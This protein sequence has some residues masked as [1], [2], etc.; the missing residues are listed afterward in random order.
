MLYDNIRVRLSDDGVYR[1]IGIDY[2]EDG[3][4][5]KHERKESEEKEEENGRIL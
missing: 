5:V 3:V 1:I 2:T 4:E